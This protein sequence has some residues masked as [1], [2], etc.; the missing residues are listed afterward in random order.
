MSRTEIEPM[1]K[2]KTTLVTS[3]TLLDRVSFHVKQSGENQT[4][5]VTRALLNQLE[6]EHDLEIRD[7]L[8]EEGWEV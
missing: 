5:F 2:D 4:E 1:L 6:A 7:M 3:K 8:R